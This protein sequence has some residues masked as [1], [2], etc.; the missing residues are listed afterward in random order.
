MNK[1]TLSYIFFNVL[2]ELWT[3]NVCEIKTDAFW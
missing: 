1:V 2:N 3:K